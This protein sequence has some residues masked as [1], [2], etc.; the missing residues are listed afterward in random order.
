MN[1]IEILAERLMQLDRAF[2][3]FCVYSL[4]GGFPPHKVLEHVRGELTNPNLSDAMQVYREAKIKP[5]LRYCPSCGSKQLAERGETPTDQDVQIHRSEDGSYEYI[6]GER[7][8]AAYAES[9]PKFFFCTMCGWNEDGSEGH[10]EDK[11]IA[12]PSVTSSEE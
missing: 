10:G 2:N 11:L 1:D 8:E 7:R 5:G 9:E 6:W 3:A 12:D 4:K